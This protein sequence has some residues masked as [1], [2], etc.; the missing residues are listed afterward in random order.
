MGISISHRKTHLLA[1]PAKLQSPRHFHRVLSSIN[2]SLVLPTSSALA[3]LIP[4][5]W[6]DLAFVI[7]HFKRR[8]S[9]LSCLLTSKTTPAIWLA[10]YIY[11]FICTFT[12]PVLYLHQRRT[13]VSART[14]TAEDTLP[15]LNGNESLDWSQC[16]DCLLSRRRDLC[17]SA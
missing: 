1:S 2:Q 13:R 7:T 14:C 8:C 10:S 5:F 9:V 4:L 12:S 17:H 6:N 3:V 16:T 15:L 11:L